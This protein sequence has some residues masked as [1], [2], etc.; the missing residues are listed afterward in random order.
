MSSHLFAYL[1]EIRLSNPPI[2]LGSLDNTLLQN[3][4]TIKQSKCGWS[5]RL[6]NRQFSEKNVLRMN[7]ESTNTTYIWRRFRNPTQATLMEGNCSHHCA[8]ASPD[9]F[10]LPWLSLNLIQYGITFHFTN[11]VHLNYLPPYP[12]LTKMDNEKKSFLGDYWDFLGIHLFIE[13]HNSHLS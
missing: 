7:R 10:C 12:R 3:G 8:C 6:F 1:T 4:K 2:L 5:V 13:I 9:P 11:L